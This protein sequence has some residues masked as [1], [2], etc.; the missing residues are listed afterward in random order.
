LSQT[1][2]FT[3]VTGLS[4]SITPSSS[5]NKILVIVTVN[6]SNQTEGYRNAFRLVRNSTPIGGG[7]AVGSRQSAFSNIQY[8]SGGHG[9]L[10][11]NTNFLDSP[12]TTSSTTYKVQMIVETSSLTGYV[13][14]SYNDS[15]NAEPYAVR[16][17]STI[18]V[19]EV[20][21]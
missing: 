13:N 11:H 9:Q 1:T 7:T 6:S 18:T 4:V 20:K 19:M 21:G 12:S 8:A 3:D 15:D 5:S 14:R 16:T 10:S 2:T 17:S